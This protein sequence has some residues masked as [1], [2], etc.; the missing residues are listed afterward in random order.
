VVVAVLTLVTVKNDA[1]WL[2]SQ[3]H[4]QSIHTACCVLGLLFKAEDGSSMFLRN[5]GTLPEYTAT[6]CRK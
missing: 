3:Q 5:V 2:G 4:N 6:C 1:V